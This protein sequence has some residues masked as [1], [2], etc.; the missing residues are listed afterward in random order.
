VDGHFL[1]GMSTASGPVGNHV[2]YNGSYST[3]TQDF[4][5]E[6]DW[7]DFGLP[8]IDKTLS[9]V[10]VWFQKTDLA[11]AALPTLLAYYDVAGNSLTG[12]MGESS[13]SQADDKPFVFSFAPK[14]GEAWKL[15]LSRTG[16]NSSV[17]AR[18][19]SVRRMKIYYQ[20][21]GEI[22]AVNPDL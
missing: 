15:A 2:W 11:I 7:L 21:Q 16:S 17:T 14:A 3:T 20:T 9:H 10:L 12:V 13:F 1:Y 19:L 18:G 5:L 4:S 22:E 8:G 6:T